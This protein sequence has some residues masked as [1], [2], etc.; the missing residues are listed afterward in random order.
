MNGL[1]VKECVEALRTVKECVEAVRNES[2]GSI[3]AEDIG[4]LEMLGE[5]GCICIRK[6]AA[7]IRM[8]RCAVKS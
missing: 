3:A 6:R 4:A 1:N 7:R 5:R 8:L 2:A